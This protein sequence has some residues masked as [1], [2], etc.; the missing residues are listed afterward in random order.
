MGKKIF[1]LMVIWGCVVVAYIIWFA[2]GLPFQR[3]AAEIASN[4]V[5]A[6]NATGYQAAVNSSPLW[7]S[8]LP[9]LVGL[10]MSIM[11]MRMPETPGR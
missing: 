1:Y 4:G 7:L 8:F 3:E 9:G 10:I 5:G 11:V 6:E 2:A